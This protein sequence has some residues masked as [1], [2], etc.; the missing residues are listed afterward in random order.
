VKKTTLAE[1]EAAKGLA[2]DAKGKSE[3]KT[4]NYR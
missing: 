4:Y 1:S 2:E 3:G